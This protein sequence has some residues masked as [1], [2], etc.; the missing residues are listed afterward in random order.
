MALSGSTSV[1]ALQQQ[2]GASPPTITTTTSVGEEDAP[3]ILDTMLLYLLGRAESE[4]E[5]ESAGPE[6]A[7]ADEALALFLGA[8]L[9][10]AE[11]VLEVCLCV[12]LL[13]CVY[14]LLWTQKRRHVYVYLSHRPTS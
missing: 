2:G 13:V 9:P 4:G 5:G 14:A 1:Q 11:S 7:M 12:C 6:G 8:L 10:Q 3:A